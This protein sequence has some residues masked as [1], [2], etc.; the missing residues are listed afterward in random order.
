MRVG[1]NITARAN[2]THFVGNN[3]NIT[4]NG[5]TVTGN[6]NKVKGNNN[7][8]TGNNN[9]VTGSNN[10]W[11]GNN[12]K[13]DG[14]AAT[15]TGLNNKVNGKNV[16][17]SQDKYNKNQG[18]IIGGTIIG[19]VGKGA[20]F[21]KGNNGN[22]SMEENGVMMNF[23]NN[24][25]N[26]EESDDDDEEEEEE[27]EE[28]PS[29]KH[30]ERSP[31]P[32]YI[33]VPMETEKDDPVKNDTDASCVLCLESIPICVVLPCMHKCMCCK[34]A[35]DIAIEGVAEQGS[36]KCPVCRSAVEAIKKVYE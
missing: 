30:R 28:I 13:L 33:E 31:S 20:V 21:R 3:N 24:N 7:T 5:N 16:A 34:C 23:N 15:V 35:R 9:H 27:E 36:V 8:G 29:K 1:N 11:T 32:K 4:G 2:N 18:V 26:E 22:W 25:N 12:N 10:A 14:A 19:S 6:N 17:M